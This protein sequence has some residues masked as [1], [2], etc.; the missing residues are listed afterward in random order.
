MMQMN[1][2]LLIV[3][4]CSPLLQGMEE[5]VWE[6]QQYHEHSNPQ[7][8]R[9]QKL[10]QSITLHG[11]E[12]I[13]D[14]GCGTGRL[15]DYLA[16]EVPAGS[17]YAF[18][19]SENQIEHAMKTYQRSNLTFLCADAKNFSVNKVF[20][21]AIASSSLHWVKDQQA[22][23]N[24]I[25]A[26]LKPGGYLLATVSLDDPHSNQR[27]LMKALFEVGFSK[28]W[29]TYLPNQLQQL[30]PLTPEKIDMIVKSYYRPHTKQTCTVLLQKTGFEVIKMDEEKNTVQFPNEEALTNH[31]RGWMGGI[32]AVAQIEQE[33]RV[34]FIA[35]VAQHYCTKVARNADGSIP[36]TTQHLMVCAK[37]KEKLP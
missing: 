34:A 37:K 11:N 26:H 10:L 24:T 23:F 32:P 16:Q 15:A 19:A 20:D 25:S 7:F 21:I 28:Q 6:G 30:S 36:Y 3:L 22:V 27:P 4:L 29:C 35:T 14:V 31:L 2:F 12:H 33:Q 9:A 17:V 18:D 1:Q 13:A 5:Q 8:Q